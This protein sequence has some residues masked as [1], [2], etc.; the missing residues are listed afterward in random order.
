V[1][2]TGGEIRSRNG[3]SDPPLRDRPACIL[4]QRAVSQPALAELVK[5]ASVAP[6]TLWTAD[7]RFA[8]VKPAS[9]VLRQKLA[10]S[11]DGPLGLWPACRPT[12]ACSR[13]AGV[14]RRSARAPGSSGPDNGSVSL[15]GLSLEGLQ[16]M[17]KSLGCTKTITNLRKAWPELRRW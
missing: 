9:R 10:R 16:L 14:G 11:L 15:C 6:A 12:R 17:R 2:T 3:T 7:A 5:D 1:F 4:R 8:E 13:Q